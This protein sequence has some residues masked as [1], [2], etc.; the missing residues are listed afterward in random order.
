MTRGGRADLV[1]CG[2]EDELTAEDAID[3]GAAATRHGTYN[4]RRCRQSP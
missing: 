2:G 4:G 1:R 3:R